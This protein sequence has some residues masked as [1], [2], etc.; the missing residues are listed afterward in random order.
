MNEA[1]YGYGIFRTG[2]TIPTAKNAA[3]NTVVMTADQN[4]SRLTAEFKFE[5]AL[6]VE[7]TWFIDSFISVF[8]QRPAG[9]STPLHREIQSQVWNSPVSR[10][11][12]TCL[13]EGGHA[14]DARVHRSPAQFARDAFRAN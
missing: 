8:H 11:C 4:P 2:L 3:A 6:S 10:G 7:G 9:F 5:P 1:T 13:L 12:R 14:L